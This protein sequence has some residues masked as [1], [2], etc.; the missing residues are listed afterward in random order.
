MR[1]SV[2]RVNDKH[3]CSGRVSFRIVVVNFSSKT[4]N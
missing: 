1:M 3:M 4:L 2:E